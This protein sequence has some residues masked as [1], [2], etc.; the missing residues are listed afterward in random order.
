MRQIIALVWMLAAAGSFAQ[1]EVHDYLLIT[2]RPFPMDR[3]IVVDREGEPR[4]SIDLLA[5]N[6][7]RI[8]DTPKDHAV[9][10]ALV[11]EY[12]TGGWELV[13]FNAY[14]VGENKAERMVWLMRKPKQ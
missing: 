1:S 14:G 8:A 7:D 10:L 13:N 9:A 6:G 5:L 3:V 2:Y 4:R 11:S 12:E